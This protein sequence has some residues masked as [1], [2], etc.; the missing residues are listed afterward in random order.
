MMFYKYKD[1]RYFLEK[2]KV[3]EWVGL[4]SEKTG[5]IKPTGLTNEEMQ[6]IKDILIY[7]K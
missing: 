2:G 4:I 6:S 7:F 3:R 1:K 5:G